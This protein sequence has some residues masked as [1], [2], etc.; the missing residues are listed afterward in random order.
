MSKASLDASIRDHLLGRV[1]AD[2]KAVDEEVL[3]ESLAAAVTGA[4]EGDYHRVRDA[5][6]AEGL[7]VSEGG[8]VGFPGRR[9]VRM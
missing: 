8:G 7:L 1:P 3:L 4:G 9:M 5:M 2:G 6:M